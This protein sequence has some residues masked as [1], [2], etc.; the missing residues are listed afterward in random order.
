MKNNET[1]S[2][3]ICEIC[4]SNNARITL[5][6]IWDEMGKFKFFDL[7][8]ECEEKA[9]KMDNEKMK[10]PNCGKT[11][12]DPTYYNS[13]P[14]AYYCMSRKPIHEQHKANGTGVV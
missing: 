7:C 3:V 14:N 13:V 4:G 12:P 5:Y 9:K 6:G 8:F 10:R 1:P 11:S 2:G